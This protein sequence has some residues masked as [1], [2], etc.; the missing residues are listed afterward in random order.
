[1]GVVIPEKDAKHL[2]N[3]VNLIVLA[4]FKVNLGDNFQ[5]ARSQF[6]SVNVSKQA[7]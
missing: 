3:V 6:E 7:I 2:N 4:H 5:S 1:M